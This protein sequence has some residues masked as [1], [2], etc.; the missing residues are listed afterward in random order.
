MTVH[1]ALAFVVHGL[2][3]LAR[4]PAVQSALRRAIKAGT[5]E[6]VRHITSTRAA[7]HIVKTGVNR[8]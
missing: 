1:S 8:A 2:I 4:H 7:E 6:L 3:Q 5:V